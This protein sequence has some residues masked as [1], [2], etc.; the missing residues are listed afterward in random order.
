MLSASFSTS[1]RFVT[2]LVALTFGVLTTGACSSNDDA[3]ALDNG[4]DDVEK[5]CEQRAS[6]T[7]PKGPKCLQ[8]LATA[9]LEKCQCEALAEFGGACE[10]Q[11]VAR[12]AEPTCTTT[13]GDCT[14]ACDPK[15]CA[16]VDRCY[17]GAD[18]CKRASA[19]QDG[20]VAKV[21]EKFCT[22]SADA[23]TD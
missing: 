7:D 21:C 12:R 4:V 15:D 9:A 11:G 13:V 19:A 1:S 5:A 22:A 2:A 16:C 10:R 18:A 14:R 20:C 8:C 6:Y 23:S 3:P 17:A